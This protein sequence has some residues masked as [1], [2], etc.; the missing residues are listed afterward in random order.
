MVGVL[1]LT[2]AVGSLLVAQE[3]AFQSPSPHGTH[4]ARLAL[5][6]DDLFA[7]EGLG[8]VISDPAGHWIVF[9]HIRPYE[10]FQDYS[11]RSYAQIYS[12][13][14]IWKFDTRDGGP[15]RRLSGLDDEATY[16]LQGLSPDGRTLVIYRYLRGVFQIGSYDLEAEAFTA[17]G[18]TPAYSRTGEYQPVWVSETAFAYPSLPEGSQPISTSLRAYAVDRLTRAWTDAWRGDRATAL[19]TIY[20]PSAA[21]LTPIPGGITIA[22]L[23]TGEVRSFEVGLHSGLQA[24]P[25]G[26]LI[27][28]FGEFERPI[29]DPAFVVAETY[30]HHYLSILDV[31]TGAMSS[32]A[33]DLRFMSGTGV[34]DRQSR[35]FAAFGWTPGADFRRG[36]FRVY[37][38]ETGRVTAMNL[39]GINL[40]SESER[41]I[42]AKPERAFFLGNALTVYG[43]Y[44]EDIDQPFLTVVPP[45]PVP[46]AE[47]HWF[48]IS[49]FSSPVALT[50]QVSTPSAVPAGMT[51]ESF[52]IA[53]QGGVFEISSSGDATLLSPGFDDRPEFVF[54]AA[55]VRPLSTTRPEPSEQALYTGHIGSNLTAYAINVAT[56]ENVVIDIGDSLPK[57]ISASIEGRHAVVEAASGNSVTLSVVT[58]ESVSGPHE[59]ASVNGHLNGRDFGT[60]LSVS[61]PVGDQTAEG[62]PRLISSC[63]L[64]PPDFDSSRPPP[65]IVDAYPGARAACESAIPTIDQALPFSP[66]LWAGRGYAYARLTTPRDLIRTPEGPI[67]GLPSILEAGVQALSE[68][69]LIDVDRVVIAGTSQGAA[70]A[71]YTA[72]KSEVFQGVIASHGWSN[73]YSHYFGGGGIAA[74]AFGLGI[75]DYERYETSVFSDF[76]VGSMSCSPEF[77]R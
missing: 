31:E 2:A 38:R 50:R 63:L 25:D 9:E 47:P 23:Q 73:F 52:L 77:G 70:T 28:G 41:S 19:E 13:H 29:V 60:W 10:A 16:Y 37:D 76:S 36:N 11:F 66:Y 75:G 54:P 71:L 44:A 18:P 30:R 45:G 48:S 20:D 8:N 7:L 5:D 14:Q 3:P 32:V 24:S 35:R 1:E 64:L 40:V 51:E 56:R 27:A 62:S 49:E 26:Q 33:R 43:R 58:N 74:H 42:S 72:A 17:Y 4:T 67:A 69:G 65:L 34:W 68:R 46:G 59:L 61:Y 53:A 39:D 21:E 15:A 57:V 22:N 6:L 12:G 55:F